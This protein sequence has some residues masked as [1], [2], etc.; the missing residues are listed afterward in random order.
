MSKM[1]TIEFNIPIHI[2][3]GV[4]KKKKIFLNY[5][6]ARN[7]QFNVLNTI[8]KKTKAIVKE[9][10]PEFRFEL[11]ELEYK[12]FLPNK[13]KRDISNVCCIVDKF[14]NDALVELDF[15][16]EDNYEYLKKVTYMFGGFDIEGDGYVTVKVIEKIKEV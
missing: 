8:K 1:K 4:R 7:L 13:L 5:N 3:V 16:P 6:I 14:V 12:L 15:V 11:Y 2:D 10:C 9:V